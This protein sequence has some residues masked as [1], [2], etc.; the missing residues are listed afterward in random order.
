M[1]KISMLAT[2]ALVACST[3]CFALQA[4]TMQKSKAPAVNKNADFTM[5]IGDVAGPNH[6]INERV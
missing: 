4:P 5:N 3:A 6:P 1:K 2:A